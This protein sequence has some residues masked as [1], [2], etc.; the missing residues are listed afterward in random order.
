[1][2]GACDLE[3]THGTGQTV[4]LPVIQRGKVQCVALPDHLS[5]TWSRRGLL[6]S[7]VPIS[8]LPLLPSCHCGRKVWAGAWLHPEGWEKP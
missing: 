7:E 5:V 8:C 3:I 4:T 6:L 2:Q 1:M